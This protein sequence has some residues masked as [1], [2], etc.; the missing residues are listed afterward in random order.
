VGYVI[1]LTESKGT[2]VVNETYEI[3]TVCGWCG[4]LSHMT[5]MDSHGWRHLRPGREEMA[6]FRCDNCNALSLAV[7]T[8]D[9]YEK[10]R[11]YDRLQTQSAR[12]IPQGLHKFAFPDVPPTIASTAEEAHHCFGIGAFRGAVLLARTAIEATA[13][14]NGITKPQSVDGS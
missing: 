4:V 12:W 14:D 6:T 7:M 9:D 1:R 13:K 5:D 11:L 2:E 8:T 10:E 3:K